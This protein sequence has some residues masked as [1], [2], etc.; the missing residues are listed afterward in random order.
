MINSILKTASIL[1]I[2]AASLGVSAVSAQTAASS[3]T[4]ADAT[5]H[6]FL[7]GDFSTWVS[8]G[9]DRVFRGE[10][11]TQNTD[12]PSVQASYT[13]THESGFYLGYWGGTNKFDSVP[14]IY[15]ES[16]PYVGMAGAIGDTGFNYNIFY[17][18]YYYH[19]DTQAAFNYSEL[20][21][22]LSRQFGDLNVNLEVT[23]TLTDWFGIDGLDGLNTALTFSYDAGNDWT[24]S[25]TVG[26]Q[27]FDKTSGTNSFP[28]WVHWD[29][30]VTKAWKGFSIDV[31]YHDT[32]FDRSDD[33]NEIFQSRLVFNISKS[34]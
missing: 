19:G 33:P 29:L 17:F 8:I 32:D 22:N 1:T 5:E 21:M 12:V 20:W 27:D 30:G 13:W 16:G 24:V 7:G 10:S 9:N 14:S 18:K 2:A 11:E 34:F 4:D 15:A 31:R 26:K 28:D 3:Q 6:D 25:S 23:P